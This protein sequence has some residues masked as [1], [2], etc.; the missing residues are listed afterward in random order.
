MNLFSQISAV[1]S[2]NVRGLRDR[3]WASLAIVFALTLTVL[4]LLGF[5]A[6]GSGIDRTIEG[7]GSE[8]VALVLRDGSPDETTSEVTRAELAV[9]AELPQIARSG[10]QAA[11]SPER[12]VVVEA[13]LKGTEND[14]NM[15]LRGVGQAAAATRPGLE[16]AEG[17]MLAEGSNEM[18]VGRALS[19][20][21]EGFELGQ[22]VRIGT[23][24]WKVVGV[25]EQGGSVNESE[26]WVDVEVL[27]S[28]YRSGSSY[29][30]ARVLL[31]DGDDLASFNSAFEADPQLRLEAISEREYLASQSQSLGS[32]L[33]FLGWPLAIAMAIGAIAGALNTMYS[34]VA[35]RKREIGTLR[36]I[37]FSPTSA[38]VGTLAEALVLAL[39]GG[40]V[41][42]LIGAM[43]F[44]GIET[45]TLGA[46]FTQVVFAFSLTGA[47]YASALILT[48]IV[49]LIGGV[50]PA[51][52]AARTRIVA[53]QAVD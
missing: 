4:V 22:D 37:G 8:N 3:V 2:M 47:D 11:I 5:L 44:N 9:M 33:T 21:F 6:V 27:Q 24:T 14:A 52:R 46:N 38:F 36:A 31:N 17:R 15:S 30:S 13:G 12:F 34:S 20:R 23:N 39:V 50:F 25:F 41:G 42:C 53:A 28:F 7:T 29:Q 48:L 19:R 45:S 35:D 43:V 18:V 16:I 40:A 10:G 32:I 49:G 51:W 26:A 1:V